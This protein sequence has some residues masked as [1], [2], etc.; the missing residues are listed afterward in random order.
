MPVASHRLRGE[1]LLQITPCDGLHQRPRLDSERE[2]LW[3]E[4]GELRL[5]FPVQLRRP[6]CSS[7]DYM[8]ALPYNAL[9]RPILVGLRVGVKGGLGLGLG[10][11]MIRIRVRP[12]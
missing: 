7:D 5:Q 10:L 8:E 12:L 3:P 2:E 11:L 4:S 9:L 1:A 6:Y